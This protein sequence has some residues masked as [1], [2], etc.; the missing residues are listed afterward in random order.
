[1]PGPKGPQICAASPYVECRWAWQAIAGPYRPASRHLFGRKQ[2]CATR[3]GQRTIKVPDD[4]K[5]C[6]TARLPATRCPAT[7]PMPSICDPGNAPFFVPGRGAA[8]GLAGVGSCPSRRRYR[9]ARGR[10]TSRPAG[11]PIPSFDP[12]IHHPRHPTGTRVSR[13]ARC[14]APGTTRPAAAPNINAKPPLSPAALR[15]SRSADAVGW[16]TDIWAK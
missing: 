7:R 8:H 2:R 14:I 16:F 15:G 12:L 9:P 1:M 4:G 11:L 10:S 13:A 5:R 6:P 3:H